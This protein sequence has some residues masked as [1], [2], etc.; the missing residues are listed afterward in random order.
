[1]PT[2]G[3]REMGSCDW[4]MVGGKSTPRP[5]F[6]ANSRHCREAVPEL[7]VSK[8][9]AQINA[10]RIRLKIQPAL[11]TLDELAA[12]ENGRRG[13]DFAFV[14]ADKPNYFARRVHHDPPPIPAGI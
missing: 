10:Q 14:D 11:Q 13:F 5:E 6:L 12:A 8:N 9:P 3:A 7:P 4:P 2:T 1:M